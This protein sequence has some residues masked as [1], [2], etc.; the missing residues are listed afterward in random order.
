MRMLTFMFS[1]TLHE[2]GYIHA[3]RYITCRSIHSWYT[4]HYMISCTFMILYTLHVCYYIHGTRYIICLPR[5]SC[6]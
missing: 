5:H 1:T 2:P 4:L 3:S 6:M